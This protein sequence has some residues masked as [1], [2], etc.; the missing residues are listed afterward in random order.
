METVMLYAV[1]SFWSGF[2]SMSYGY[3]S[4]AATA[5]PNMAQCQAAGADFLETYK[6]GNASPGREP[7]HGNIRCVRYVDGRKVETVVVYQR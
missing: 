2:G 1:L 3:Q 6:A 4:S 7:D 5:Q